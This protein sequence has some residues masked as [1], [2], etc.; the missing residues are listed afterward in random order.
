MWLCTKPFYVVIGLKC[1][2]ASLLMMYNALRHVKRSCHVATS[3]LG[4]VTIA[5]KEVHM[6][7]ANIHAVDYSFVRTVVKQYAANLALPV[8]DNVAD[9]ALMG[10]A[11]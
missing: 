4:H 2:A 8:T 7:C 3:V 11:K 5:T 9:V 1:L 10:N 6:N